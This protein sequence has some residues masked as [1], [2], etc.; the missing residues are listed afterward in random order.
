VRGDWSDSTA[1]VQPTGGDALTLAF[2]RGGRNDYEVVVATAESP[3]GAWQSGRVARLPVR[4]PCTSLICAWQWKVQPV[5]AVAGGRA[6][7]AVQSRKGA[8]VVVTRPSPAAPWTRPVMLR[9]AGR[10]TVFLPSNRVR[11]GVVPFRPTCSLPPCVGTVELRD[12]E[13]DERFGRARFTFRAAG[14][15]AGRFVLPASALER[16]A[17]GEQLRTKLSYDVLEGDGTQEHLLLITH[18]HT[19]KRD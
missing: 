5:L 9:P 18:L 13:T 12:A 2:V 17:R 19:A 1:S 15:A 11:D 4:D 3:L 6:A 10:T 14:S 7:I 16:P 8:L